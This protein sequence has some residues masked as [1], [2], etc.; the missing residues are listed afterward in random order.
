[1][2]PP[3][4]A[5]YDIKDWLEDGPVP[6]SEDLD[7]YEI[8]DFSEPSNTRFTARLIALKNDIGDAAALTGE[9]EYA[10]RHGN[11]T[12]E[13]AAN[14]FRCIASEQDYEAVI[15]HLKNI[16]GMTLEHPLLFHLVETLITAK[17]MT[18]DQP[19][20]TPELG[21][22]PQTSKDSLRAVT[23]D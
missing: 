5:C 4:N 16:P 1:V 13:S 10:Y 7:K 19:Y 12:V 17:K 8:L 3:K 6:T 2:T 9:L 20:M 18:F 11:Y 15:E 14:S 21:G 22:L 23:E